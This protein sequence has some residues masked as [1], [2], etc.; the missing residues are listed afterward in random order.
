[1]LLD[2]IQHRHAVSHPS[3]QACAYHLWAIRLGNVAHKAA[4]TL[5]HLLL[6][7]QQL[8]LDAGHMQHVH[9]LH[10]HMLQNA[11]VS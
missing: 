7:P 11:S 6:A 2:I 9:M 8:L 1:M 4:V 5:Q 3:H 10:V